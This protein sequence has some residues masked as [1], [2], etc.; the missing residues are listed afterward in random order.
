MSAK[1]SLSRVFF[2]LNDQEKVEF[3]QNKSV[4][5]GFQTDNWK[6]SRLLRI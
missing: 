4:P 2:F 1:N 3:G 6:E 5:S